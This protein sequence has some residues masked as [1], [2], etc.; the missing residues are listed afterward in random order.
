MGRNFGNYGLGLQ[1]W[2]Q[3]EASADPC[4][5]PGT[6]KDRHK[7][8][9]KYWRND[10]NKT[11]R[12]R[13]YQFLGD[14]RDAFRGQKAD[15]ER[16]GFPITIQPNKK[17][18]TATLLKYLAAG[19]N[20]AQGLACAAAERPNA[21][22]LPPTYEDYLTVW[23]WHVSQAAAAG[24]YPDMRLVVQHFYEGR[25]PIATGSATMVPTTVEEPAQ[26]EVETTSS[27]SP[28]RSMQS[29]MRQYQRGR[30]PSVGIR[31]SSDV[32]A[33]RIF[34]PTSRE[35]EVSDSYSPP[36]EVA[37]SP[38]DAVPDEGMGLGLKIAI[39]LGVLGIG[40]FVA[41]RQGWI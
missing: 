1:T 30:G 9:G 34:L 8:D 32:F 13:Y 36:E 6:V 33:D 10:G 41:R 31:G 12:N 4:F 2:E 26:Q 3:A 25:G 37:I 17:D 22:W 21:L 14:L 40:A 5:L 39:G 16:L 11:E 15:E 18:S 27:R 7:K 35:G 24:T 29:R 28:N 20:P 19:Y 38:E 23:N